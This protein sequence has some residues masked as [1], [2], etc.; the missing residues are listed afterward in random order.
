MNIKTIL[1]AAMVAILAFSL[2][3]CKKKT[4]L[5][6]M[7]E[8]RSELTKEDTTQMLKLADGCMTLLKAQKYDQALSMLYSYNDSTKEVAPLT[9]E[10]KQHYGR[11]FRVFPVLEYERD[12][13][14]F[15]LEGQNDVKYRITFAP[16]GDGE[17][18]CRTAL[19]F[20][21]VKKDGQW[22]LTIKT[23]R[24]GFDELRQ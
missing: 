20:N 17:A 5:E 4:P 3:S 8:F 16:G 1:A 10:E 14:S 9:A 7:Q 2:S 21:P 15:Q 6:R 24:N 19:M 12:Y 11:R 18:P 23:A 22:Y 13:Y